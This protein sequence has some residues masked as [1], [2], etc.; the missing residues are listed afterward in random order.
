MSQ[1]LIISIISIVLIISG[2]LIYLYLEKNVPIQTSEQPTYSSP[3]T[4]QTTSKR[5]VNKPVD[6]QM[7]EW[8]FWSKCSIDGKQK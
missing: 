2:V 1:I 8:S 4:T 5:I 3:Q 7:S 6:C